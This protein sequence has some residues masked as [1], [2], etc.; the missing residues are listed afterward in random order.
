MIV[1]Y[2]NVCTYI[3]YTLTK[4]DWTKGHFYII[5]LILI[6]IM[7]KWMKDVIILYIKT[8]SAFVAYL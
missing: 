8:I 2:L 1:G 7:L 4:G 5:G 3:N 6:L